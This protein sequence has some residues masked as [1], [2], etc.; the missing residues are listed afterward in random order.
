[1]HLGRST[2]RLFAAQIG[3]SL[4][5]F[6]ALV[7]FSQKIGPAAI[8]IYF[9][10]EALVNVLSLPADFGLRRAV[11]KRISEGESR[12]H[13]L[14]TTIALK[15]G[16]IF[17]IAIFIFAV[18]STIKQYL[19]ADLATLLILAI[20]I[21]EFALLT[22]HVLNA[23]FRVNETA[24]LRFGQQAFWFGI[25]FVLLEYGIGFRALIYGLIMSQ[26]ITA[27]WGAYKI[28]ITPHRPSWSHVQS[29]IDFSKFNVVSQFSGHVYNWADLLLI[30][31]FL[32]KASVG[33]YEIAWRIATFVAIFSKSIS[34]TIFPQ[35]SRWTETGQIDEL[36]E[37]LPQA[38]FPS[39]FLVV[40]AFFGVLVVAK[41][42]LAEVFGPGFSIAWIALII[43]VFKKIFE[44]VQVIVGRYLVGMNFPQL[45]AKSTT[46]AVLFNIVLNLLLIPKLGIEGA[47]IATTVSYILDTLLHTK[48][49]SAFLEVRIPY[50]N[51]GRITL[52]GGGMAILIAIISMVVRLNTRPRLIGIVF[53]GGATY[54]LIALSFRSIRRDLW[55]A[56][57]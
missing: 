36:E 45:A 54:L 2:V 29:L 42:L 4:V 44:A 31:F 25:G 11:E 24:I 53:F 32:S 47:A 50:G 56:Y 8:G 33:S 13:Y 19:N 26:A 39:L 6:F 51:I 7:V 57:R 40:P 35:I 3:R 22:I 38:V 17:L 1:M 15:V 28:S 27:M 9:L 5:T 30:G 16:L 37:L 41:P 49:L 55:T 34:T 14:S 10:F 43:L 46:V 52:A 23:E 20:V 21:Q 12:G 18:R 48:Y